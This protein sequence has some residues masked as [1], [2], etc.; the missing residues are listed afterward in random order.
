MNA[1]QRTCMSAAFLSIVFAA[2]IAAGCVAPV[3]QDPD[4][5]DSA[6]RNIISYRE[7]PGITE[8]EIEALE[9]LKSRRDHFSYGCDMNAEAFALSDGT[10]AG[11]TALFCDFLTEFFDIPFIMDFYSWD[12]MMLD[13][14]SLKLDFTGELTPTPE[15]MQTYFMSHPIAERTLAV[16]FNHERHEI[17]S[18]QDLEGLVIGFYEGTITREYVTNFYPGL[19][20]EAIEFANADEAAEL[21]KNGEI[22]AFISEAIETLYY[23]Q[24]S[25]ITCM[26][27]FPLVYTPVSMTTANPELSPVISVLNRYLEQ[28]GVSHLFDL[29][30]AG[31]A[32][33]FRYQ[34]TLIFSEE[35]K[36]YIND[37][38]ARGAKVPVALEN[39]N[40]PICFYDEEYQDFHGI[41]PDL[42]KE[43]HILTGI[44][45]EAVTGRDTPFTDMLDMLK[46]GEASM[47][48]QLLRTE[49]RESSFIWTPEPYYVSHFAFLSRLDYPTLELY[50]T[51]QS[52]V[53]FVDG[54]AHMEMYREWF[55]NDS[56]YLAFSTADRALDALESGEIDL[57]LACEYHIFYQT[58]FRE[59]P[60]YKVN[61]VMSTVPSESFFGFA[62][63]EQILRDVI[64]KAQ[65]DINTERIAQDWMNRTYDYAKRLA[66]QRN[67]F[68]LVFVTALVLML[69]FVLFLYNKNN[70][71]MK[72]LVVAKKEAEKSSHYKSEF[73]AKMSHEMRT[74][75][76]AIIG[77]TELALREKTPESIHD[78]I[79]TVKQAG[80]NLLTIINDILDFSKIESGTLTI[81]PS[82]YHFSSLL[83]DVISI[84][85][86]RVL[87]KQIRFAVNIDSNIPNALI[88]DEVRIRQV[89]INVLGN[90]VKYTEKGFVSFSIKIK[91]TQ[92]DRISLTMEIADSGRGIRPEDIE[93]LFSEYVQVDVN[94]NTGIEGVGLGL[95]ISQSIL[96]EMGGDISA[97]SVYGEG[98]TF[99]ITLPQKINSPE[100]LAYVKDPEGIK[101]IL[102][103]RRKIYAESIAFTVENL[104]VYCVLAETGAKLGELMP[105]GDFSHIFVSYELY[106]KNKDVIQKLAE[107]ATIVLLAEFGETI[108]DK[109]MRILAMPAHSLSVANILNNTFDNYSYSETE[110]TMARF[111]APDARV[112]VVDDISANLVVAKGLLAPYQLRVDQCKSGEEAIKAV[113]SEQYDLVFMD[114]RMPGMDGIEATRIIRGMGGDD[115]D[116]TDMPIIALT[117]NAITGTREMFLENGFN[118][119]M[120]KPIDTM[121]LN[122]MLE[123]WLPKEKRQNPVAEKLP[124]TR[125]GGKSPGSEMSAIDIDGV[126]VKRGIAISGGMIGQYMNTLTAF[127]KDGIERT[128]IISNCLKAGNMGLYRT[129]V[130]GMK[131]ALFSI[132]ATALAESAQALESAAE[133]NDIDYTGSYTGAFL[134]D[135][136]S[137]LKDINACLSNRASEGTASGAPDFDKFCTNLI[138]LRDAIFVMDR[139]GMNNALVELQESAPT[140]EYADGIKEISNKIILAE[141]DEAEAMVGALLRETGK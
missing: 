56:N 73:L 84:I 71:I 50:Q 33:F 90:A 124:A 77:M 140:E 101:V 86:M 44:E 94:K 64:G 112:L 60:G 9:N 139:S 28:G 111:I 89:L 67:V 41:V 14:E 62:K 18:E 87:D 69:V 116:K 21:L 110:E 34:L 45:F 85:R 20:F 66:E 17:I 100:K 12:E 114:H 128:G 22:D 59:K 115:P 88:G 132:G 52:T 117:A 118:D 91:S 42:L 106:K 31:R 36:A 78:H 96:K 109:E 39:D 40:Y 63:H 47:V 131:G 61:I 7:L 55:P 93:S 107:N 113:L 48:S 135:L 98:S 58:N 37:L 123:T 38:A 126:D 76:N 68:L 119:F 74:P 25:F 6:F 49:E 136:G 129:H 79:I 83:N 72:E 133:S 82:P 46:S 13:F 108:P 29:Y 15:R 30:M 19:Q 32:D 103:E 102:C 4:V 54:S 26:D 70:K 75:M 95:A 105:Q 53:G 65:R 92:E 16:F 23:S 11:F 57:F 130:H 43:I 120:S 8:S 104:G 24:Y 27:A 2:V 134:S 137:L 125:A 3:A 81:N 99:S 127:Y 80:A 35:E 1:K 141:Y 121:K 5:S 97:Q 51:I 138:R 122:T 10:K